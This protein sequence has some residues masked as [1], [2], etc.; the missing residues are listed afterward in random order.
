[1]S[2][3]NSTSSS[4]SN[5]VR[6]SV[7]R[8]FSLLLKRHNSDFKVKTYEEHMGW[9]DHLSYE[10][11]SK[12]RRKVILNITHNIEKYEKTEI[13]LI[14]VKAI[15]LLKTK[16]DGTETRMLLE[17]LSKCC[18]HC[19]NDNSI[20]L[21]FYFTLIDM[22]C[23]M[24]SKVTLDRAS[25]DTSLDLI[26]S[27]ING[28][29]DQGSDVMNFEEDTSLNISNFL[30]I[31]LE[32]ILEFNTATCISFLSLLN[33]CLRNSAVIA[34][35]LV[36]IIRCAQHTPNSEVLLSCFHTIDI[37]I[38]LEQQNISDQSVKELVFLIT[39][40]INLNNKFNNQLLKTL[41]TLIESKYWSQFYCQLRILIESTGTSLTNLRGA[42]T[43]LTDL[44]L[45]DKEDWWNQ[46]TILFNKGNCMYGQ[47]LECIRTLIDD[48]HFCEQQHE[49]VWYNEDETCLFKMLR[50]ILSV[51]AVREN[52]PI[53]I[54]AVYNAMLK[55]LL[56]QR[57]ELFGFR[58]SLD[59]L[60]F[61]I[62][63]DGILSKAQKSMIAKYL[64][65]NQDPIPKSTLIKILSILDP[66]EDS[67]A[68]IIEHLSAT[69]SSFDTDCKKLVEIFI[70]ETLSCDTCQ[71]VFSS[72]A[73]FF[74]VFSEYIDRDVLMS[75][76]KKY[77]VPEEPRRKSIVSITVELPKFKWK[78]IEQCIA[79]VRL[80][81]CNAS[82][83]PCLITTWRHAVKLKDVAAVLVIARILMKIR[84]DADGLL[85][86]CEEADIDGLT[87]TLNR[88]T[89]INS[90]AI[91]D[92]C[93]WKYP[94]D[95]A[96]EYIDEKCFHRRFDANSLMFFDIAEWTQLIIETL[97]K[98]L[99][100]EL[101]TYVLAHLCPQL[102][103]FYLFKNDAQNIEILH[104]LILQQLRDGPPIKT[105]NGINKS[106]VQLAFVRTLSSLFPYYRVLGKTR[107]DEMI[108]ITLGI[109]ESSFEKAIIPLLHHLTV[110]CYEIPSSIKKH[111]NPLLE[112]IS[113][114]LTKKHS[115]P[116]LLEFLIALSDSPEI[117]SPL[118]IDQLKRVFTI[119]FKLI[120]VS[121]DLKAE[122]EEATFTKHSFNDEQKASF[123]PSTSNFVVTKSMA[124]FYL[125]LSYQIISHWFI[126]ISLSKR[127]LIAPFLM[128]KLS[129]LKRCDDTDAYK[130]FVTRFTTTDLELRVETVTS[131]I[132]H[133]KDPHYSHEYW[134]RDG[135]ILSIEVNT[136]TGESLVVTRGASGNSVFDVKPLVKKEPESIDLFQFNKIGRPNY[137][138]KFTPGYVLAHFTADD[139]YQNMFKIEEPHLIKSIQLVDTTP[140]VEF[141][142]I[143]LIYMAPNDTC[144]KDILSHILQDGS[145]QYKWFINELGSIIKLD[146]N[147]TFYIGGLNPGTDGEYAL[148][149]HDQKCQ[150]VFHTVSLMPNDDQDDP[151]RTMK[152][153][154]VGNN[155]INI[156]YDER[157]EDTFPFDI[158]KSQFNFI[159][160]VIKPMWNDK[161]ENSVSEFYKVK[162]YRAKDVPGIFSTSHFKIMHKQ[163]LAAYIRHLSTV[164]NTFAHIWHESAS[165]DHCSTW[166]RR[167]ARIE[168]IKAKL[169]NDPHGGL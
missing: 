114:R 9:L 124:H 145:H 166:S 136:T 104:D 139:A 1:M 27:C 31:C 43:I 64:Q 127:P 51:A 85:Y 165:L 17:L 82:L 155:F 146:Q 95:G 75:Y 52:N 35:G 96:I 101:Y 98:P 138:N 8:E 87:T 10:T 102:A 88:N 67:T 153:R 40:A 121:H 130:D 106:D 113:I 2:L 42:V 169:T 39:G 156:Y 12:S 6:N 49:Y 154:H 110:S 137:S 45:Q 108:K 28:L 168:S 71:S 116:S 111:L 79:L 22:C 57:W 63:Y 86:I 94:E 59:L 93:L 120:E 132:P 7:F 134:Y 81:Q 109:L 141:H 72:C 20:R 128:R 46:L 36:M 151:D 47:I 125:T 97:R 133:S 161:A 69:Y 37:L 117:I 70:F 4:G 158:I 123:D 140:V 83:F 48:D 160:I 53:T 24:G 159:N 50:E 44:A 91:D 34:D 23:N 66:L 131:D 3:S 80:F 99:D 32:N 78:L 30:S 84:I 21:T 54:S 15:D 112:T 74:V 33:N 5:S 77:F 122:A 11:N 25:I 126:R 13:P 16:V 142:K 119:A 105:G 26:F 129:T 143:G 41:D 118:T 164:V 103:N 92:S 144:E 60:A 58:R 135:K 163:R 55:A 38:N 152:K 150:I 29:T 76:T 157:K 62:E 61:I 162:I 68:K 100:W 19:G 107:A 90:G 89:M 56:F 115:I 65:S 14:W 149:W 147:D 18:S 73:S 167:F 148:I